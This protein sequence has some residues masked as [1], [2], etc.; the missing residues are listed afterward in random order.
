MGGRG[1]LVLALGSWLDTP[2]KRLILGTEVLPDEA[3]V[4]IEI[5]LLCWAVLHV[6]FMVRGTRKPL[7]TYKFM[8]VFAAHPKGNIKPKYLSELKRKFLNVSVLITFQ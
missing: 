3:R 8:A 5:T 2:W 7:T 6:V 4:N 1:A